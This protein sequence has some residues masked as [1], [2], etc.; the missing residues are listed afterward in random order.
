MSVL[1]SNAISNFFWFSSPFEISNPLEI[2][3]VLKILRD[4]S[5]FSINE[6]KDGTVFISK[7]ISNHFKIS[8]PFEISNSYLYILIFSIHICFSVLPSRPPPKKKVYFSNFVLNYFSFF[9]FLYCKFSVRIWKLWIA[10]QNRLIN[11]NNIY[12]LANSYLNFNFHRKL[13]SKTFL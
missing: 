3:W 6:C 7:A 10:H 11:S 9:F 8:S 13:H 1:D 2:S 4:K 12:I 5:K